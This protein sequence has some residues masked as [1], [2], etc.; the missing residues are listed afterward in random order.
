ME[1]MVRG[2]DGADGEESVA[3]KREGSTWRGH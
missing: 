3:K 1:R 2:R